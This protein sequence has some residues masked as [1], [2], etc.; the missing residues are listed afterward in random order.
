MHNINEKDE[1]E[2]GKLAGNDDDDIIFLNDDM[3]D[4]GISEFS[5]PKSEN[6]VMLYP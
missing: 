1:K 3:L 5:M 4:D 2:G 6:P